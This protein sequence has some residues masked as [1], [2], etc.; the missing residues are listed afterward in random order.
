MADLY[1]GYDV[2]AKRN[3]P[4]W[5]EQTRR[6]IAQRLAVPREPRF[7]TAG[8]FATLCA[9]AERITPQPAHRE[10][11]PVAALIDEKLYLNQQDGYR[12]A[13]MPR[14][15]AAWQRGLRALEAEAHAAHGRSFHALQVH[16]QDRLLARMQSGELRH[17]AWAGMPSGTFFTQRLLYDIVGAYWSHPMAWSEIGWGGPASPRGYVRMGYDERDP[18]EAAEV[19][20]GEVATARRLNLR[21]R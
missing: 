3:S 6:V 12:D 8:E 20:R 16:E 1:P 17:E 7:L 14:E 11:I 5:N 10:A 13:S 15:R 19:R 18:W 9:V 4:S 2:L 21:V